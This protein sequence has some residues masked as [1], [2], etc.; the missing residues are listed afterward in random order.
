[1]AGTWRFDGNIWLEISSG[2][3][4]SWW[5][6]SEQTE[7]RPS[8]PPLLEGSW[9]V[10]KGILLL[11]IEKTREPT[12][13][14]GCPGWAMTFEVKSITPDAMFLHQVTRSDNYEFRRVPEP[15]AAADR[16]QPSSTQTNRAS[17]AAG[18]GS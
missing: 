12:I 18:S 16:S 6:L 11:L 7:R 17:P 1:M 14:P 2:G 4:W 13:G 9:F 10:R 5:N 15:A 8:G 3:R